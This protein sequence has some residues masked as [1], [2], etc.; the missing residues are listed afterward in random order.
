MKEEKEELKN[1]KNGL[2]P[3]V[4]RYGVLIIIDKVKKT[5]RQRHKSIF[6]LLIL[7]FLILLSYKSLK[8]H[9]IYDNTNFG[10]WAGEC[11]NKW[12]FIIPCHSHWG[13]N[14][15]SLVKRNIKVSNE[16]KQTENTKYKTRENNMI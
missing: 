13:A 14:K 12:K 3:S 1:E 10:R 5:L 8:F 2:L 9:V 7:K 4:S 15:Q 6:E 16:K 11:G